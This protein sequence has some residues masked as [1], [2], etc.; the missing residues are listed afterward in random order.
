MS[1]IKKA[2]E[3]VGNQTK[4]AELLGVKQSYISRWINDNAQA[5][6]KYIRQISELTN[7]EVTVNELLSD[8]QKEKTDGAA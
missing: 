7:N 1:A 2:V 5:P 6:A 8:H 3:C 4:L